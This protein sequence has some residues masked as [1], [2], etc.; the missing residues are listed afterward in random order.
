MVN[1]AAPPRDRF[2][3]KPSTIEY[4]L[5]TEDERPAALFLLVPPLPEIHFCFDPYTWGRTREIALAFLEWVWKNTPYRR[6]VGPVPAYN[7][8]ARRLAEALGFTQFGVERDAVQKRGRVY[9]QTV[10]S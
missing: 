7:R 8:L 3:V 1:D 10:A 6:L 4:V 2:R 9:D 5:A